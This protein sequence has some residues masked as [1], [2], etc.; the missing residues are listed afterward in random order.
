[1]QTGAGRPATWQL[2]LGSG[3]HEALALLFPAE[4]VGSTLANLQQQMAGDFRE[5]LLEPEQGRPWLTRRLDA[6]DR[7]WSRGLMAPTLCEAARH[8][9]EG[10]R[11]TEFFFRKV[12]METKTDEF[13]CTRTRRIAMERVTKVRQAL[14]ANLEEPPDLEELAA[15]C[16]CNP[17]YL[18]RTFSETAGTT[19]SLYL[20]Q[21][22]VERAAELIAQG[23]CNASEAALEVGYRSLSHFSQAFRTEKGVSPSEWARQGQTAADRILLELTN[24]RQPRRSQR[25]RR[26]P[27]LAI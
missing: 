5:L 4:W 21:L 11:M 12:L 7:V 14:K 10:S 2:V 24:A 13:F 16:G 1:M 20:R 8:L 27:S 3:K 19:I 26:V 9:L 17:Q 18:S 23:R 6:E 22:R 15:L 25:Q